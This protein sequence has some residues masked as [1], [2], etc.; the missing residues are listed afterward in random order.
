MDMDG[1][2]SQEN[3]M[4]KKDSDKIFPSTTLKWIKFNTEHVGFFLSIFHPPKVKSFTSTFYQVKF[5]FCLLGEPVGIVLQ[6][7]QN[8]VTWIVKE[9]SL[10]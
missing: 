10:L 9:R 2:K 4:G 7:P 8:H 3:K 1:Y 5:L 6:E